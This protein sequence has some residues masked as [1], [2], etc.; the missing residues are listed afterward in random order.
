MDNEDD[1]IY[2]L[3]LNIIPG[4]GRV[5]SQRLVQF[6]DHPK[7]IF[8]AQ[9]RDLAQIE[10]VGPKLAQEI[11]SFGWEEQVAKE[12]KQIEERGIKILTL[13]DD[14]YPE[15]L[16]TIPDPPIILYILG[17][18]KARDEVALAVIGSRSPTPYGRMTAESLSKALAEIGFTI[19]SGMARGIDSIAHRAAL[20]AGSRTIAV[21]G[22]G[23]GVVY[24][25]ENR[26]LMEKIAC[27]GA[28]ISE[29]PLFTKPEK[30]NFPSRNR[31]ISGLSLGVIVIEAAATS[32]S[33]ITAN[34]AL[35]QNREVFAVPGNIQSPKSK[36]SNWLIKKGAKLVESIEDILEELPL[37]VREQLKP[38][39][40]TSSETSLEGLTSEESLILSLIPFDGKDWD[41]LVAQSKLPP[42]R[43]ASILIMLE[44]KGLIR[45]LGGRVFRGKE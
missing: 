23:L 4:V 6:F 37:S 38:L 33:L 25:P 8:S 14:N 2:W 11:I 40:S 42:G 44:L 28:V 5:L 19:V 36:G 41:S 9:P 7:N 35:E 39:N 13:K 34:H 15:F 17:E 1:K 43:V 22:S 10:G 31:L 27:S 29:F 24:P 3:A 26:S 21:L 16:K 20:A 45:Q 32:G 12:F 18:I 30:A